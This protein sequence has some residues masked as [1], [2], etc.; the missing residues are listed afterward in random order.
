MPNATNSRRELA[1]RATGGLEI[2]LHWNPHDDSTTITVH[3]PT[4]WETITFP[5]RRDL[6]LHAFH[7]PFAHLAEAHA[8][9]SA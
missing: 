8:P 2:T 6:A 1:H 3:Q 7:H 9:T 5:V 4:S